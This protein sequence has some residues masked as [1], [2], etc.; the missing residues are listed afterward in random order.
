MRGNGCLDWRS[1]EAELLRGPHRGE[2]EPGFG[3]CLE[4]LTEDPKQKFG[5]CGLYLQ[6][7]LMRSR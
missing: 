1:E 2:E 7:T 6:E 3:P 5:W 4:L